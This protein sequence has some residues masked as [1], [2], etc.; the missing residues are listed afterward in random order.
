VVGLIG[1]VIA[2]WGVS[3]GI[4]N[5]FLG[6]IGYVSYAIPPMAGIMIADYFV[7]QRMSYA[8]PLDSVV[9]VNWRAIWAFVISVAISLYLGLALQDQLWH[10]I[11]IIGFVVYILFSIP[12]TMRAWRGGAVARAAAGTS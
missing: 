7:V 6:F 9:P 5:S 2:Y 12:Q 3:Q 10:S 1:I 8:T 11:P 4:I